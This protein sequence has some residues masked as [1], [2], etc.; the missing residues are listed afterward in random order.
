MST[1]IPPRIL[2]ARLLTKRISHLATNQGVSR[3]SSRFDTG[4]LLL[5][6]HAGIDEFDVS[7]QRARLSAHSAKDP[8]LNASSRMMTSEGGESTASSTYS[9]VRIKCI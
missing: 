6:P 8:A 7:S 9:G 3:T 2:P 4:H 5:A 1:V